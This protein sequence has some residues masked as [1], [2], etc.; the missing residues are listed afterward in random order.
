MSRRIGKRREGVNRI[1][2]EGKVIDPKYDTCTKQV[3]LRAR[4]I[5][6]IPD[7]HRQRARRVLPDQR[8]ENVWSA[9][10]LPI[11]FCHVTPV[12]TCPH[13]WIVTSDL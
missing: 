4:K 5:I 7:V 13:G 8:D 3:A 6:L 10:M 1:A 9:I 11:Y 2:S 12:I